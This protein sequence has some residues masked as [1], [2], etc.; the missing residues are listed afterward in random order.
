MLRRGIQLGVE[1]G[2]IAPKATNKTTNK[3]IQTKK[4]INARKRKSLVKPDIVYRNVKQR[5]QM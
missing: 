3:K 2:V 1:M 4:K 5:G